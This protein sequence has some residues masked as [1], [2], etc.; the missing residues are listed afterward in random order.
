MAKYFL[1]LKLLP[2]GRC[3]KKNGIMWGKFPN[4]GEVSDPNP[5]HI[6][7]FFPIQGLVKWQ[8][9]TVKNM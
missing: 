1:K 3:Q 7:L 6:F 5:L 8:Q 9:N 2:K 4:W